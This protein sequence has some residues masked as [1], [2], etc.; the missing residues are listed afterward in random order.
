[1]HLQSTGV[2]PPPA[3][4][5]S[6]H[7]PFEK[8][9]CRSRAL[10]V[11]L[12]W[13]FCSRWTQLQQVPLFRPERPR[14]RPCGTRAATLSSDPSSGFLPLSTVSASSRL[15]RGLLDPAVRHGPHCFAALFH[16]AHVTGASLQSFPFPR[17]RTR[18]RG[19]LLPCGFAFDCRRRSARGSFTIDFP[20][21]DDPL[22]RS[23][24]ESRPRTHWPGR[25]FPSIASPVATT[26]S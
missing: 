25:R 26:H 9:T 8:E 4:P 2:S 13:S 23:P 18:S 24:P 15:A 11:R 3:R 1:V 7:A 22:P 19:P 5:L 14:G 12:S 17:S 20:G 21:R 16:A 10:R 6:V